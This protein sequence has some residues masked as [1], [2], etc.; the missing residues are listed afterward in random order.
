MKKL[1]FKVVLFTTSVLLCANKV[2]A[3]KGLQLGFELNPQLSYLLNEDDMNSSLYENLN[4]FNGHFGFSGQYG[5]TEKVGVGLNLLYSVQGS[6]YEWKG[7][8]RLKSLQYFK[9]PLMFTLSLPFGNNMIFVGKVGP[10]LSVLTD[11]RLYDKDKGVIVTDY[12]VAFT[13]YDLG[14]MIS[15]GVAYNVNDRIS[16][17]GS[18]RYDIGGLN[19]E[20]E[21]YTSNIH[22]PLDVVTPSPASSPRSSTYNST[23]GLTFGIRYLFL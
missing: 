11:A 17:D 9:I 7:V 8:E 1:V 22:N 2:D 16:I 14:G 3:Q 6:K 18:L 12:S 5:F 21:D 23:L 10:Q 4:A 15:A 20:E 13:T 19:A